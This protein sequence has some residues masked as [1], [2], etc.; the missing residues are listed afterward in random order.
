MNM[1]DHDHTERYAFKLLVE[2]NMFGEISLLYNCLRTA[3]VISKNYNTMGCITENKFK[4]LVGE[5]PELKV[6]LQKH[7]FTYHEPKKQFYY[8]NLLQVEYFKGLSIANFHQVYFRFEPIYLDPADVL[9]Y[10]GDDTN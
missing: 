7:V 8:K 5:Y 1:R 4:D 2:G 6:M 10:D 9:L 3:S